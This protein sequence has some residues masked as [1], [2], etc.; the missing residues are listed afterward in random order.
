[1]SHRL[2]CAALCLSRKE[3]KPVWAQKHQIGRGSLGLAANQW[4]CLGPSVAAAVRLVQVLQG[5]E[6]LNGKK[7]KKKTGKMVRQ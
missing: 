6:W 3:G 2:V 7:K 4:P 5:E 1:M